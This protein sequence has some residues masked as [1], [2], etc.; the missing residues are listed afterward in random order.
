MLFV[1]ILK[2]LSVLQDLDGQVLIIRSMLDE[3]LPRARS[4]V[5]DKEAALKKALTT[6]QDAFR[7]KQVRQKSLE[8]ELAAKEDLFAKQKTLQASV[9]KIDEYN[10]L[11]HTL[12]QIDHEITALEDVELKLLIEIDDNKKAIEALE[13]QTIEGLASLKAEMQLI[14]K[15][16][17]ELK[18]EKQTLETE[19][20]EAQ[21]EVPPDWL[22]AYNFAKKQA[23]RPPFVVNI[24]DDRCQGCHLKISS[25]KKQM[26]RDLK[27]PCHCDTC[28]RI[29]LKFP[30]Q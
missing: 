1:D 16:V 17:S 13:A 9:K 3:D 23:K 18:K 20:I 4:M 11:N 8:S 22:N 7:Q 27:V 6:T 12:E 25:E 28:N 10:A 24:Q 30:E 19:A 5:L 29:L 15:R 2:K 26:A 14:D 21:K